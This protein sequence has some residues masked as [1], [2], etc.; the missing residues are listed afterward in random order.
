MFQASALSQRVY[1]HLMYFSR[2]DD[3]EVQLKAVTGLG[4]LIRSVLHVTQQH[5][6]MCMYMYMYNYTQI[7]SSGQ[8]LQIYCFMNLAVV[9]A[10]SVYIGL[11]LF[12]NVGGSCGI[13]VVL[14]LML[15]LLFHP[16]P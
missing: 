14:V 7:I 10:Y 13:M 1:S 9:I 3:E 15:R 12:C 2:H 4:E 16:V 5:Q 8:R 11:Q 6:Y